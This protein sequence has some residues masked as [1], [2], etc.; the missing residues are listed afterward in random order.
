M[1]N[2][3]EPTVTL[4]TF[5]LVYGILSVAMF[6]NLLINVDK[7]WLIL[8]FGI[9]GIWSAWYAIK[10]PERIARNYIRN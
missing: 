10:P 8:L 2:A 1:A 6:L 9:F 3:K 7:G 5:R 4:K